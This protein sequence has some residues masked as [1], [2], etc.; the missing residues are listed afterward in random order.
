M[1]LRT[2]ADFGALIKSRRRARKIGQAEMAAA[3]G[4]SRQWVVTMEK[5]RSGA[6]LRLVLKALNYLGVRIGPLEDAKPKYARR[7]PQTVDLDAI[8]SA[9]RRKG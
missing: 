6:E 2:A 5:G 3:I 9:G 8:V 7:Q 4:V 1:Q